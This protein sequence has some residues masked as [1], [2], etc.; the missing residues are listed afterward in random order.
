MRDTDT[1]RDRR[2]VR[3]GC[4]CSTG[5]SFYLSLSLVY[6]H[7]YCQRM[8]VKN[9]PKKP[10]S[11]QRKLKGRASRLGREDGQGEVDGDW[12]Q[13][14]NYFACAASHFV[15][16]PL[17][18]CCLFLFSVLIL[19][20]YYRRQSA[21]KSRHFTCSRSIREGRGERRVEGLGN[22]VSNTDNGTEDTV[23]TCQLRTWAEAD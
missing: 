13:M 19:C 9:C 22:L 23:H 1:D 7:F 17:G 4:S 3:L 16:A 12:A 5:L 11:E 21:Y 14:P 18:A 2:A 10:Q 6:C 15:C 20:V 8:H